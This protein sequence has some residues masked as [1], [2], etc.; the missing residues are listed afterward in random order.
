LSTWKILNQF[1]VWIASGGWG[2]RG[3]MVSFG[4]S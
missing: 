4:Y 2:Q 3:S 1:I